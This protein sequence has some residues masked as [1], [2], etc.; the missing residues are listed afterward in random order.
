V[1]R[2]FTAGV[3]IT[4]AYPH[5]DLSDQLLKFNNNTDS[6]N[7]KYDTY[8]NQDKAGSSAQ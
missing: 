2:L 8:P 6:N 4:G 3:L 5:K 7:T 1:V